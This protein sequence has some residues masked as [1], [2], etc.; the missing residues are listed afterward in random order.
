MLNLE[1]L[2]PL[3]DQVTIGYQFLIESK[4]KEHSATDLSCDTA[5]VFSWAV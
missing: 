3:I 2:L 5:A 4:S 1:K